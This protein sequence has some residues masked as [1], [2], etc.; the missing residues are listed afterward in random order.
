MTLIALQLK[1]ST[2][3][4]KNLSKLIVKIQKSPKNSLLLAPELYLTG[5]SYD[6]LDEASLI[7]SK[8]IKLLTKVSKDKIIAITMTTKINN[9]YY[10]T[11]YLLSNKKL[12]HTQSKLKLF[13]LG[14]EQ[15]YFTSGDAKDIKIIEINGIKIATL[16]CFELRFIELWQKVKG[17]DI[18]LIPAMWG[19]LRK[20]N[21][22]SLCNSL[23]IINQCYVVASDSSNCNM[24]KGSAIIS[25]F[26]KTHIDD[27]KKVISC[28]FDKKEI[29]KMRKY[30]QTDIK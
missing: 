28:I 4:E 15:K 5:Y 14:A 8:A 2:N 21:Y 16:I 20:Q 29:T 9:N 11:L 1:T 12:L 17:A 3:F 26:G 22:Q 25:P 10:N 27:S 23:A 7:T 24:A 30:L 6:R 13:H 19:K 18:I